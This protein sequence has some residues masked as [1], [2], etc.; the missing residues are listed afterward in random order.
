MEMRDGSSRSGPDCEKS[1]RVA[2][3]AERPFI[4]PLTASS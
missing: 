2:G 1:P 4:F 3:E